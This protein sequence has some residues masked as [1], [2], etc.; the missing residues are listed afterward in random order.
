[1]ELVDLIDP[2]PSHRCDGSIVAVP[3][4]DLY[5][6]RHGEGEPVVVLHGGFV[7]HRSLV[8]IARRLSERFDVISIDSRG[9]GRSSVRSGPITYGRMATD[10]VSV[11]DSLAIERAHVVGHSDGGCQSLHLLVDHPD[12]IA[13][14][15]LIGTPLHLDDYRP[16][17]HDALMGFLDALIQGV[18]G[19]DVYGFE[20]HFRS[21]NPHPERWRETLV[22]LAAT[23]RVEPTFS[24]ASLA[25]VRVPVL[26]IGTDGD[27]FL[28]TTVFERSA[29]VFPAGELAWIPGGTHALTA[30]H[31]AEIVAA[32]EAFVDSQ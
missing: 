11:L 21:T 12:R 28:D 19:A 8:P 14:A 13:S 17:T 26:V 31:P 30:S 29:A 23:W 16:G 15:T 1:M 18:E 7:S 3:G 27:E 6:E 24:D 25:R 4:A 32:I 5:V 9:Q 22:S 2:D 10:V 20:A